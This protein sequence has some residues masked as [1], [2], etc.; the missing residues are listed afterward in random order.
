M[1]KHHS[2]RWSRNASQDA[3]PT[4]YFPLF[5]VTWNAFPFTVERATQQIRWQCS[6]LP[7]SVTQIQYVTKTSSVQDLPKS[8]SISIKTLLSTDNYSV[9]QIFIEVSFKWRISLSTDTKMLCTAK[10]FWIPQLMKKSFVVN[11][12]DWNKTRT[13]R[14][15][16]T[17]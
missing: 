16:W 6:L 15:I 2:C 11:Y 4:N 8:F 5:W 12:L 13:R 14:Y 3:N 10:W 17:I 7:E 9:N 1:C